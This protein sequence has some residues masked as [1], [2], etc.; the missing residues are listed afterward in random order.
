MC[1]W[2][3]FWELHANTWLFIGLIFSDSVARRSI[4]IW[5]LGLFKPIHSGIL[6]GL[7]RNVLIL[8]FYL[9]LFI[10]FFGQILCS[11]LYNDAF[12]MINCE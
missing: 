6:F 11:D 3:I 5:V 2:N 7:R 9:S 8:Y 4:P 10:S 1:Q 12:S